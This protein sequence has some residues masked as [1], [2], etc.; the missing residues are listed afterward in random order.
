M[1]TAS[2][3]DATSQRQTVQQCQPV[4]GQPQVH[5][6]GESLQEGE[7]QRQEQ[8]IALLTGLQLNLTAARRALCQVRLAN[9]A[10]AT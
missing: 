5:N 8:T 2:D 6:E 9:P 1:A 7:G 3:D 10:G 4:A